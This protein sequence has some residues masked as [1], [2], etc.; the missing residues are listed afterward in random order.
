MD[1]TKMELVFDQVVKDYGG[2]LHSVVF[3]ITKDNEE[4][5]DIVQDVFISYYKNMNKFRNDSNLSTY[6][7]RIAVNKSI[8]FVRKQKREKTEL[9][10]EDFSNNLNSKNEIDNLEIKIVVERA[11]DKLPLS[12]RVPVM[13]LEYENKN[14]E[15]ISKFLNLPLNT[16]KTRISRAREKLL[17]ILSNMGATI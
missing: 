2:F 4:T 6:L 1:K 9:L 17:K 14:Y 5:K 7:Y 13:L 15:E 8:D 3:R 11:L 16:V 10:G 12:Y